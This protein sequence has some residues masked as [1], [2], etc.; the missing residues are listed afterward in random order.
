MDPE[1]S[2]ESFTTVK[3]D[4]YK[5]C[6]LLSNSI[7]QLNNFFLDI[8]FLAQMLLSLL[9]LAYPYFLRDKLFVYPCKLNKTIHSCVDVAMFIFLCMAQTIHF[10]QSKTTYICDHLRTNA[11]FAKSSP[12]LQFYMSMRYTIY[13]FIISMPISH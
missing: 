7:A 12:I 6:F 2:K 3:D 11:N 4:T 10:K 9:M 13:I 5:S 8:L 1:K